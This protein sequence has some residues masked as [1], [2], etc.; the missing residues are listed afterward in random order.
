MYSLTKRYTV[1][2]AFAFFL[3]VN[4]TSTTAQEKTELMMQKKMD[5]NQ[6][7]IMRVPSDLKWVDGPAVLPKG[8]K[9]AVLEG[10]LKKPGPFTFRAKVP[11]NY[12][13]S[14]H[15]HPAAEHITVLSGAFYMGIGDKF[16]ESKAANLSVGSFAV[17][18]IGTHHYAFTKEE[19]EIQVHGNGQWDI[20]YINPND[21][22]R[23]NPSQ[24]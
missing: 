13:I 21:D 19:T 15:Y 22:P 23:N 2:L 10:D 11:A 4:L 7:H 18:E 1:L 8:V 14:P 3:L 12:K 5:D 16:D 24:P 6:S 17:M 9:I 20:I